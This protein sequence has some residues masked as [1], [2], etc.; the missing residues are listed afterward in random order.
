MLVYSAA[1]AKSYSV[2]HKTKVMST[3]QKEQLYRAFKKY[4]IEKFKRT[5]KLMSYNYDGRTKFFSRNVFNASF[6]SFYQS[7]YFR[8]TPLYDKLPTWLYFNTGKDVETICKRTITLIKAAGYK[9]E[10]N[11]KNGVTMWKVKK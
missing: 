6:Y 7:R 8:D 3:S 9:A 1:T 10:Y 4:A 11:Y 5:E 2:Y